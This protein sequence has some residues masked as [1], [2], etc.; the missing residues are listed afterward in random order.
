MSVL[1]LLAVATLVAVPDSTAQGSLTGKAAS[2]YQQAMTTGRFAREAA[3]LK[4]DVWPTSDQTSFFLVR[5]TTKTPQRWIV[6][7]HGAGHPAKGFATDD[8]ATWAPHLKGRDIGLICLQWWLGTGDGSQDFLT[9]EQIYREVDRALQTLGVKPGEVMLHGFS[10][11]AANTYAVAAIDAGM[12]KRYFSLVVASSGSVSLD[13]PPNRALLRGDYGDH[14][15]K[16]TRW[17]TVAGASDLDP[18]RAGVAGMRS[19]GAWL[20]TQG[21]VLIEAIE[22][23]S[24][25]HGALHRN[26]KNAKR[27]LDLFLQ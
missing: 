12:G 14:P 4:P 17:V 20:K 5:R 18:D 8:L 26:P 23:P 1:L 25:G 19:T 27:V 16:N 10:R 15:L 2:L 21:A 3:A 24:S 6:S 11:G 13:Y 9:P 7:L 22:D